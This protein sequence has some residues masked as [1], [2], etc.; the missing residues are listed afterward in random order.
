M[1]IQDAKRLVRDCHAALD[2][3]PPEA[4]GQVLS[5]ATGPDYLWRG[6]HPFGEMTGA[7][8]VA[9]VAVTPAQAAPGFAPIRP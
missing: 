7:G 9:V 2:R 8:A 3:A 5:D 6:F 4:L 1:D